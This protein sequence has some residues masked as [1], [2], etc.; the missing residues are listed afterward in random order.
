MPSVLCK[1]DG[2][3]TENKEFKLLIFPTITPQQVQDLS[4][5]LSVFNT[6]FKYRSLNCY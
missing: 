3:I 4:S 5:G 6:I 1:H 2:L